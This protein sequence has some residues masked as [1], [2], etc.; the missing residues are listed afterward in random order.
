METGSDDGLPDGALS[1]Q[2]ASLRQTSNPASGA[3]CET[4]G[5]MIFSIGAAQRQPAVASV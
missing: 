4:T 2:S 5:P 1:S 3:F